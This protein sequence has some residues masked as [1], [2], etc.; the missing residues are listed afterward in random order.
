MTNSSSRS[1][2]SALLSL[3]VAGAAAFCRVQ[4]QAVHGQVRAR[5]DASG[6]GAFFDG[7]GMG[8]SSIRLPVAAAVE[9]PAPRSMED[10]RRELQAALKGADWDI[11][12]LSD[13]ALALASPA[14]RLRMIDILM[15]AQA[16][17]PRGGDVGPNQ[18]PA[19]QAAALRI[20]GSS[21]D[22]A[23]FDWTYYRAKPVELRRTLVDAR[24]LR[25]LS[26]RYRA[27][28][29]PGDWQG[30]LDYL[31]TAAETRSSGRNIIQF[32]IDGDG[33]IAPVLAAI[34]GAR[35][36]IHL[37]V[38]QIQGDEIGQALAERLA[39]KSSEGVRV[40]VLLDEHG[41]QP[42]E[43]SKR[44]T[45]ELIAVMRQGGVDVRVRKAP[46][47]YSHLDHRKVMVVDGDVGFT[48]GMNVGKS[49][50]RD[51]HD[52]QTMIL[53]PAVAR[54]QEAFLEQW[55]AA[56]GAVD[57]AEP[58]V[59]PVIEPP[60][61]GV[62]T[63]VVTH[64]GGAEDQNI[65][66]AYI[67]AIATAQSAVRIANPYFVDSDVVRA[68]CEAAGRG[69]TVQVVLPEDN[70]VEIVQRGSRA[71]YP[72]LLKAGVEVH[73][74]QGRMAH[75]KVAVIDSLWTTVGSSNLD[76]RSL[77]SND[78]LNLVVMDPGLAR[79]I[80]RFLFEADI[81]KSKRILEYTPTLRE[82]LDRSLEDAL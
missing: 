48:G 14:E 46:F 82:K 64:R 36:T 12:N 42:D 72:D 52:Q 55:R 73:E 44:A 2:R 17:E 11:M 22:A 27:T 8:P 5:I 13:E 61:N 18:G 63:R 68:L 6:L 7:S 9:T 4:A 30:Y 53:G 78:E 19:R 66:A 23:S 24:A 81:R 16:R 58:G 69:A 76:A 54:L 59:Y 34:E 21:P 20:L 26:S 67:R 41:T 47:L 25:D 10:I 56:A 39:A 57:P 3:S 38:F 71:Y 80:E 62:E 35:Y 29:V 31:D 1:R 65:K 49:Y 50:Q 70:D 15:G 77:S 75:E 28:A 32:L 45:G 40:R 43:K 79:H 60:A 37:E 51:W 74:Y 33:V